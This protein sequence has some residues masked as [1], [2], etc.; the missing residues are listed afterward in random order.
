MIVGRMPLILVLLE[1]AICLLVR[2]E[3]QNIDQVGTSPVF[4]T[5]VA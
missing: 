1:D 4:L 5:F 3:T 2:G